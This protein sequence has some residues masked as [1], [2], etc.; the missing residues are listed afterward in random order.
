M[1]YT[2]PVVTRRVS[3]KMAALVIDSK[4]AYAH[5]VGLVPHVLTSVYVRMA[6][7]VT[8]QE[9]VAFVQQNGQE[10]SV[11]LKVSRDNQSSYYNSPNVV[12]CVC[13]SLNYSFNFT[14][15]VTKFGHPTGMAVG[16]SMKE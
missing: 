7:V 15:I 9:A 3:V 12:M 16:S 8:E 11:R 2:V 10:M 14:P 4:V 13:L 5:R 1:V 6:G